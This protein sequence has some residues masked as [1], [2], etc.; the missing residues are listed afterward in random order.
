[1]DR[2][3]VWLGVQK[4]GIMIGAAVSIVSLFL[5]MF[6]SGDTVRDQLTQRLGGS[7]AHTLFSGMEVLFGT[8]YSEGVTLGYLLVAFPLLLLASVF[9]VSLKKYR[10][11]IQIATP[12]LSILVLFIV[13]SQM[14]AALSFTV[15]HGANEYYVKGGIGFWLILLID[16]VM[17]GLWIIQKYQLKITKDNVEAFVKKKDWRELRK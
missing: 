16:L 7:S 2:E 6:I 17:I 9:V 4:Y 1:M 14:K 8:A 12:I 15:N 11:M 10:S 5:T 13:R 3:R